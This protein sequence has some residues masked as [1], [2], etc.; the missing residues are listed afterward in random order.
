MVMRIGFS[1]AVATTNGF[2]SCST[3]DV[4]N[5][6]F[7]EVSP[8]NIAPLCAF[9]YEARP[10]LS[11]RRLETAMSARAGKK[12]G[13]RRLTSKSAR[14]DYPLICTAFS[15][16]SFLFQI[17]TNSSNSLSALRRSLSAV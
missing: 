9:G 3:L 7:A 11:A 15:V 13:L 1:E 14:L 8:L 16:I 4:R 12:L 6:P 5:N 17:D 10:K 2:R